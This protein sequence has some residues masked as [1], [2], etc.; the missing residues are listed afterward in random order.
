VASDFRRRHDTLPTGIPLPLDEQLRVR[1][2]QFLSMR[3]IAVAL[4]ATLDL[5]ALLDLVM[6]HVTELMDADRSTL[7]LVDSARDEMWSKVIQ[8]EERLEIRLQL[9]QGLAGWVGRHGEPLNIADAYRDPRF[10]PDVDRRTGYRTRSVLALPVRDARGRVL[11]VVQVLNKRHGGAFSPEDQETLQALAN[12]MAVAIQNA[13][14]LRD[15]LDRADEL[16]AAHDRLSRTVEELDLLFE[17][18]QAM[19]RAVTMDDLLTKVLARTL[20]V[21]GAE[22]GSIVLGA[23]DSDELVFKTAIGGSASRLK[24]VRLQ[25]GQGIAGW[26]AERGEPVLV[27][28]ARQDPRF[29]RELAERLGYPP[30]SILCVPL[31]DEGRP[32]GAVELLDKRGGAAFSDADLRLATLIA[33]Q[34]AKGLRAAQERESRERGTRLAAIGQMLSA[35]VHD[36]K[37]PMTAIAGYVELM[38][39]TDEEAERLQ[40]CEVV[41][42]QIRRMQEMTNELL[43]FARGKTTVLLHKVYLDAFV[44]QLRDTL[45]PLFADTRCRCEVRADSLGTAYMDDGKMLRVLQNIARNA[46]EAMEPQGGGRFAVALRQD[47]GELEITCTDTGPGIPDELAGRLFESFATHGKAGGTGLGLAIVKKIVDEHHGSIGYT[48]QR[49]QGTSFVLRIPLAPA[50]GGASPA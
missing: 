15:A 14:L 28:D 48:S 38:A 18:E 6:R 50:T 46:K 26:V 45:E 21:V 19:A 4:G 29:H 8:G 47:G 43:Q 2:R 23:A 11:G 39:M 35:I 41:Y 7:Y 37:T 12:Q 24:R 5:D 30:R 44:Q 3:E 13:S 36:F 34:V 20:S 1:T 42:Q 9:G 17:V 40:Q 33:S 31:P 16:R 27:A 10:H 25:R 32:M 22:A 49:G